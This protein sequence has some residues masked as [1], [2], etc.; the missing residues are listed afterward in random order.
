MGICQVVS[1]Q[2]V[3]I[4]CDGAGFG[5]TSS[6]SILFFLVVNGKKIAFYSSRYSMNVSLL[7]FSRCW[8]LLGCVLCLSGTD[9]YAEQ[10]LEVSRQSELALQGLELAPGLKANLFSS[11]PAVANPVAIC[12]DG[13]GNV[14]VCETYRQEAGVEDNRDHEEWVDDD[15]A[16]TS[17]ADRLA[18][19][20]RHLKTEDLEAYRSKEERVRFLVDADRDGKA[21]KSIVF[22]D[23][24]RDYVDGTGAGVLVHGG[25]LYYACIPKLYAMRDEDKDGK[26]DDRTVMHDGFGVRF[27]YRGHDLH[28]LT[29]GMDRRLYFSIGDRGYNVKTAKGVLADPESG[30]VFRCELNGANLEV[31]ATGFRNPQ[32]LAF[33]DFGNL[34]TCDNNSDSGD[35]A[36]WLQV[37]PGGDYGWRMAYQYFGD[38]GPW[39][40]ESL[41][42]KE[43]IAPAAYVIPPIENFSD[44]PAGLAYYPGTGLSPDYNGNFFLCDFRGQSS[45]SG[46]RTFKLKPKG[47]SFE[48]IDPEVFVWN[49]LPTDVCFAPDGALLISDWVEGWVGTG[50]GRI[51][52]VTDPKHQTD[53]VVG[54]VTHWLEK[55][56]R[57]RKTRDLAMSLAHADQ[58][59]RRDAHFELA[60]RKAIEPLAAIAKGSRIQIAQWHAVMGLSLI[61]RLADETAAL[62]ANQ[63]LARLLGHPDDIIRE[64]AV[65]VLGDNRFKPAA[66]AIIKRLYDDNSR[67]RVAAG[68]AMGRIGDSRA[69]GPLLEMLTENADDDPIVRHAA[70]MGLVGCASKQDIRAM[71]AHEDR[72]IRV[73]GV[74]VARRAGRELLGHFLEDQDVMVVREAARAIND[75]PVPSLYPQLA[76]LADHASADDAIVRR[77]LNVRR[78]LAAAE[79]AAFLAEYAGDLKNPPDLRV[80]AFGLLSDWDGASPRDRVTGQH[81]PLA[82]PHDL[83]HAREAIRS[84]LDDLV[85]AG[86]EIRLAATTT[87]AKLGIEEVAGRLVDMVWDDQLQGKDRAG[88]ILSLNRMEYDELDDLCTKALEEDDERV[89]AAARL[90]LAERDPQAAIPTLRNALANGTDLEKQSAVG[91]MASLELDSADQ[92]LINLVTLLRKNQLPDFL[93]LDVVMAADKRKTEV[94][95]LADAMDAYMREMD[96]DDPLAVYRDTL[97][98]G[99]A[100]RG[101]RLFEQ[102]ANLGCV[103]CH[104]VQ[105]KGGLVGPDLSQIAKEKNREYLLESIILP[106]KTIAKG[107][108]TLVIVTEDGHVVSGVARQKT[109]DRVI[110]ITEEGKMITVDRDDIDEVSRGK[111][112]MPDDLLAHLTPFDLRDLIE[113]LATLK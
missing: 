89:R 78:Y 21:D 55:G 103:R 36:R 46:V 43:A 102:R 35:R 44:G 109:P 53:K 4:L 83:Q 108:D 62:H 29:L 59:L 14:F 23:G 58:R 47:A 107:F 57:K 82:Q 60:R 39:N 41:W 15:L 112:A 9:M 65:R 54:D 2:V 92:A 51:F 37:H 5:S 70:V 100:E 20:K 42:D 93:R 87:A 75:L 34:F 106:D 63:E 6:E 97:E 113:Y 77:A 56:M 61:G 91:V 49:C 28:G 90:V 98:G 95:G 30:A 16:A 86:Q 7:S 52:R 81:H 72:A 33:D 17:V 13:A 105:G 27:A 12:T 8:V 18:L 84:H 88:A 40:R 10:P 26:A 80:F 1:I 3:S 101:Q 66:G 31:V 19:L 104:Q 67:V 32:E 25:I 48:L 74:L 73:A 38:R 71:A 22:V 111:S 94:P 68:I 96:K 110:L 99:N 76:R 85:N 79:D 50:K 64:T 24:F 69:T 11:E 45:T